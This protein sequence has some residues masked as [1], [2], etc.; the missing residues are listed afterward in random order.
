MD[1]LLK[2]LVSDACHYLLSLEVLAGVRIKWQ[3]FSYVGELCII[4]C[5]VALICNT[6]V[7]RIVEEW[8]GTVARAT[9]AN[10]SLD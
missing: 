5:D 2:F 10:W 7:K 9:H 8:A 3:F 4:K 1:C 6:T